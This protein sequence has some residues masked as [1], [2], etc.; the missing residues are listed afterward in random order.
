M[1]SKKFSA[2]MTA[3]LAIFALALLTTGTGAIAQT[4][5]VLHN[6]DSNGKDGSV[7]EASLIFDSAGNL[8]GTTSNGGTHG[9]GTV[10][11]MMPKAGGGWTE[12]VLHDFYNDGKDGSLPAAGLILDAA[13]NLYGTTELGGGI[14]STC[15]CGTVFELSPK[16][17]RGWTEKLLHSFSQNG[18]DGY[19]PLAGLILDATGNLYGTTSSGGVYG[20]GTVFEVSPAAGEKWTEKVVYSFCSQSGCGDGDEPIGGL[21]F[22]PAGNLYGTT[23][24]GGTGVCNNHGCGNVFELTPKAG[25]G[26]TETSLYSFCSQAL[27]SDGEFPEAGLSLDASGNLYGT[28]VQGG[29]VSGWGTVFEISPSVGGGWTEEVLYDFCLQ[30]GCADG[31]EPTA[32]LIFDGA[33]NLYSTTTYGGFC[34]GEFS[35]AGT[36]FELTPVAGGGWA[37]TVLHP[38]SGANSDRGGAAPSTSLVF[39]KVGNLYGTTSTGGAYD[40]G[41]VF[42]VTP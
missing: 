2:V 33:G 1:R 8:Y 27:C 32:G 37:E 7:P 28:T 40:A 15:L 18:K 29:G 20:H 6:F 23:V 17:G 10:F 14:G 9:S 26:W 5:K 3:A 36:V 31:G 21:I 25:G 11:E 38:F 22:D 12:T 34:G 19:E 30:S 13:G 4:E 24:T 41:V 39:D 35:C 16:A 42:E